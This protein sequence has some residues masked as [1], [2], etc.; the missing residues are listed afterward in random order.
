MNRLADFLKLNGYWGV[1]HAIR[2][3][4][5]ARRM[6]TSVREVKHMAEEA[7]LAGVPIL[8]STDKKRGGIFL[9]KTE[10]EIEDGI[11][12]MNRMALS[13]LRERGA[14]RRALKERLAKLAQRD[15]FVDTPG[16]KA[17]MGGS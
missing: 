11:E 5:V 12:R 1:E 4:D 13:I 3:E 10:A 17:M 7:R 8:Y 9:A 14:L 6:R 2:R 16:T 15:L